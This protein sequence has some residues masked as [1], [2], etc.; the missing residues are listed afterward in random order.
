[1]RALMGKT[2]RILKRLF[3]N[4]SEI[5][6][7]RVFSY[8]EHKKYR[9][10]Y[11]KN[12]EGFWSKRL[13]TFGLSL[14]GVGNI[15]LSPEEN[16]RKYQQAEKTFLSLCLNE[17]IDFRKVHMLDVGC[18]NGF[19]A[20]VFKENG[21]KDY[22]G[23]DIT[24]VLFDKLRED[25]PGFQF[26]KLDISKEELTGVFDLIVMID[27]TQHIVREDRFSF[28]MQ[29]IQSHLK[30]DGVFIVTSWLRKRGYR[31]F[32]EVSRPIEAYI[33][34][35]PGYHFSSPLPFRDKFIFSIRKNKGRKR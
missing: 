13:S 32:Y 10:Q 21:G 11:W 1:M 27:V 19:Y 23:V 3:R 18:G 4:P 35:F 5:Y 26:L 14:M 34:A 25:F 8:W 31:N 12:P 6:K 15:T 16:Q 22:L 2:K 20:R 29:N 7:S 17:R 9:G 24:D 33:E 28:A 30:E